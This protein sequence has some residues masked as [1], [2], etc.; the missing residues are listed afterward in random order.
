MEIDCASLELLAAD[1]EAA[2]NDSAASELAF[3][4]DSVRDDSAL[5][6]DSF[7][8]FRDSLAALLDCSFFLLFMELVLDFWGL[9]VSVLAAVAPTPTKLITKRVKEPKRAFLKLGNGFCLKRLTTQTMGTVM[10]D[11]KATKNNKI[12]KLLISQSPKAV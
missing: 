7:S 6:L 8:A 3:L 11:K 2:L 1:E 10:Q 5:E 9:T 4:E 12:N